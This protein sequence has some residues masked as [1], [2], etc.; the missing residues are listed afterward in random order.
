VSTTGTQAASSARAATAPRISRVTAGIPVVA[1]PPPRIAAVIRNV[2]WIGIAAHAGFVPMFALLGHPR[3]AAFNVAS[4]AMWAA[5]WLA[6]RRGKSTLGMWL[7]TLEVVAHAVLC[8]STLGWSSG[9]QYYLIPLIP[10]VMF[11]DRLARRSVVVISAGVFAALIALRAVAPEVGAGGVEDGPLAVVLRYANLA[12]PL[13]A[14]AMVS[15]YFRSASTSAERRME[16]MA[17]TDP[18]TGLLNRRSMEQRLREAAQG[19]ARSGRPF[20]VVMADVDHFKRVNDVHGHAVGDRVLRAVATL[21]GEGL[22][23]HDAV[24]R[25]G[26]EEFLLLLPETEAAAACEVAE[27]LRAAAEARLA[28]AAAAGIAEAVTLTFGVAVFERGMRV[29]ECLKQ[30]DEALYAGKEAGRNRVIRSPLP[31]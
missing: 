18:L 5:A 25:W 23:A 21:F 26:G 10:F 6:N 24:A 11:N 15:F 29:G 22:R 19:F 13:L 28:E 4:V 2:A 27:R 12:I 16:S 14:L 8:V 20:S 7:L 31:A 3:L 30:A 1:A 17:L 9:F